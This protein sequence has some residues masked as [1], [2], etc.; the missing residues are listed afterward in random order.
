MAQYISDFLHWTGSADA[1]ECRA[2]VAATAA[3][4]DA[5]RG[6]RGDFL[7]LMTGESLYN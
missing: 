6:F 2:A 3:A 4:A 1:V 5:S 7:G